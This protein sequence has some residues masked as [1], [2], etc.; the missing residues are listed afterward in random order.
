MPGKRSWV[1]KGHMGSRLGRPGQDDSECVRVKG[2]EGIGALQGIESGRQWR[3]MEAVG[4]EQGGS[5][6][7]PAEFLTPASTT[8]AA[9]LPHSLKEPRRESTWQARSQD[10]QHCC[11][12]HGENLGSGAGYTDTSQLGELHFIS[13]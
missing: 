7:P 12:V 9:A 10:F 6:L 11:Q 8:A 4:S 5:L 3:V 2:G 13:Y 1:D